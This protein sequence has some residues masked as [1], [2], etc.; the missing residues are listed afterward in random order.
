MTT[1]MTVS[2]TILDQLGG[3]LFIRMT[4]AKNLT[5]E[6]NA[7]SFRLPGSG[8]F[9]K[10]GINYVKIQL[11]AE[12]TYDVTFLKLRGAS[13]KTIAERKSIYVDQLRDV[14]TKETG[15]QTSWADFRTGRGPVE[16]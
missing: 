13:V 16:A 9:T 2:K 12:D 6:T 8:G 1:D 7:L 14:F 10:S 5:G 11:N 4:G 15:L 3:Y